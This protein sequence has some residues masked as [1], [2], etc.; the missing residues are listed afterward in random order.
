MCMWMMAM[1]PTPVCDSLHYM[2]EDEY[3]V[4]M[5]TCLVTDLTDHWKELSLQAR[6]SVCHFVKAVLVELYDTENLHLDVHTLFKPVV[7]GFLHAAG[8]SDSWMPCAAGADTYHRQGEK[9]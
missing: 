8:K 9:Q 2:L 7:S 3:A 1:I 6:Q 5:I 4:E